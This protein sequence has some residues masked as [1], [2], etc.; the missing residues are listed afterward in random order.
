MAKPCLCCGSDGEY[1]IILGVAP[2]GDG[3]HRYYIPNQSVRAKIGK[4]KDVSQEIWFCPTCM[5]AVEDSMRATILYLQVE[6]G[7][8]IATDL[9]A[10]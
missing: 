6:N 3:R 1:S 9:E 10:E 5:R 7:Q 8:P 2:E 4:P